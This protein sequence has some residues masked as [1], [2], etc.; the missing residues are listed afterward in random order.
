MKLRNRLHM[1][2]LRAAAFLVPPPERTDWLAEWSA[3]V[4]YVKHGATLFCLGAFRD[5]FWL[6]RN[7]GAPNHGFTF[8]LESPV[9]CLVFLGVLAAISVF[10]AFR[11]SSARELL[12]PGMRDTGGLTMLSAVGNSEANYPTVTVPQY[13]ALAS[14]AQTAVAFYAPVRR[15]VRISQRAPAN[16]TVALASDNLFEMLE[17]R[18]SF[19]PDSRGSPLILS[20]AAWR[21]YFGADP[22]AAGRV[23]E[24]GGQRAVVAGVAA[25]DSWRLPGR[26][27]AWLLLDP[28][29]LA[30]LSPQAKGYVAGRLPP[31]S[32]CDV[33]FECSPPER[34]RF[35]LATVCMFCTSWLILP[36]V[37]PLGLGEYA[38]NRRSPRRWL[39]LAAKIA[40]LLPL[41][42]C[43]SLDVASILAPN[44]QPHGM[45]AGFLAGLHWAF[46][47]QRRRCPVCLRLLAHPT[48]IGGASQT[49]LEWYG[50][51]LVCAHGHGL[52]YV[53][54]IPTSSYSAPRWQDLDPS[55]SSLFS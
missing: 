48:R 17:D 53:P 46:A 40:L 43:G 44:L 29:G 13:R 9:R 32:V 30:R 38:S 18:I 7:S 50:T 31:G 55:W 26:P 41:V 20:H 36:L 23:V 39:F 42:V 15:R 25:L 28:A 54:E 34:A 6:R 33:H 37:S 2:M 10:F 19:A 27:D 4:C 11:S 35:V 51:E 14:R 22:H 24:V 47:D 5:A 52:L 16:W 49:F 12:L 3:E 1:A 8:G 45:L 21:R